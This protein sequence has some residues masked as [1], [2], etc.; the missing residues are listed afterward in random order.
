MASIGSAAAEFPS[1][2]PCPNN[3]RERFFV[4]LCPNLLHINLS[5]PDRKELDGVAFNSVT[6]LLQ[7]YLQIHLTI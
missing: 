4:L 5:N 2:L 1:A 3:F 6:L 7:I